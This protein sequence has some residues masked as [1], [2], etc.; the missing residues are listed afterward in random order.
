[1]SDP[2]MFDLGEAGYPELT[3]SRQALPF[4]GADVGDTFKLV[5]EVK[6]N[7]I[8][9]EGNTFIFQVRKV[10]FPAKASDYSIAGRTAARQK[11][12]II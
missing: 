6:L 5:A 11:K 1:M 8:M 2:S 3:I 12:G 4:T 9:Q 7:N 10:G